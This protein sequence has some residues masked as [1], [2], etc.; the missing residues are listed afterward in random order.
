MH[1]DWRSCPGY[2]GIYDVSRN[3]KVVRVRATAGSRVGYQLK[4]MIDGRGYRT[5]TLRKDG[6][7]RSEK[8]HRLVCAAFNGPPP[9]GRNYVNHKDG[10][11]L[12]NSAENLEWVSH[13]ENIA[14]AFACGFVDLTNRRDEKHPKATAVRRTARDGST[15]VFPT[16]KAAIAATPGSRRT[17]VW[18]AITGELATHAGHRWHYA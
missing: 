16:I 3:G 15:C 18:K 2:E 11:K 13:Q 7:F 5:Y 8:A 12:N 4:G 10:N 9:A 17:G 14:H 6:V 1:D